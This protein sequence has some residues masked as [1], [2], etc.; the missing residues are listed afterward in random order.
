[1]DAQNTSLEQGLAKQEAALSSTDVSTAAQDAPSFNKAYKNKEEI[2]ERLKDI[3]G[4]D[5]LP[6]KDEVDYL[7]STFYRIHLA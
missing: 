1:M 4:S 7:K 6:D 2:I 5:S 3:A